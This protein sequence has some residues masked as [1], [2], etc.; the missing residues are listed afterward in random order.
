[1]I[2][3]WMILYLVTAC[4]Y[5]VF[6][7]IKFDKETVKDRIEVRFVSYFIIA[8]VSIVLIPA[9]LFFDIL[10]EMKKRNRI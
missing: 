6:N 3:F 1:M 8:L 2:W 9:F 5:S 4:L 10:C 7:V